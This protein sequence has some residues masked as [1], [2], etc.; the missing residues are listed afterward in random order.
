VNS[1][2][3]I[4]DTVGVAIVLPEDPADRRVVRGIRM[5]NVLFP[6]AGLVRQDWTMLGVL[7]GLG[8]WL[9]LAGA[10]YS[11]W[12]APAVVPVWLAFGLAGLAVAFY[13][14]GQVVVSAILE[15]RARRIADYAAGVVP[16]MRAA[17]AAMSGGNWVEAQI[18]I[19]TV[20]AFDAEYFEAN[21]TQARLL[22]VGGKDEKARKAYAR[23]RRLDPH[24]RW[25]WE[26]DRE[27]SLLTPA[28]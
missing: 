4:A 7:F 18:Q 3:N 10:F 15:G 2:A 19:E 1:R 8:F 11:T 13:L 9:P 28:G 16:P 14:G 22:A 27:L 5:A 21:L 23:C 26:I 17:Y 12:I 24:G 20:L 6:G 25:Q